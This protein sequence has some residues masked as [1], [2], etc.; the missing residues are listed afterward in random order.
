MTDLW[1]L[2]PRLFNW[3]CAVATPQA[4][5]KSVTDPAIPYPSSALFCRMCPPPDDDILTVC[6][7]RLAISSTAQHAGVTDCMLSDAQTLPSSMNTCHVYCI[8]CIRRDATAAS[9]TRWTPPRSP[10]TTYFLN[11]RKCALVAFSHDIVSCPADIAIN[12]TLPYEVSS[13]P[14]SCDDYLPNDSVF[15]R[16]IWTIGFLA[17]NG[18]YVLIDNRAFLCSTPCSS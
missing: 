10:A 17:R 15:N 13:T 2:K 3:D 5:L 14:G 18:F 8:L 11:R 4:F 6:T 9:R 1:G 7:L 16:F 12:Y